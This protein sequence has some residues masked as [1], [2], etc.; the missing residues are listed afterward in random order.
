MLANYL[1]N[2][3]PQTAAVVLAKVQPAY[4]AKVLQQ[5]D[6]NFAMEIISRMLRLE[7]VPKEVLD[8]IER[9]LRNEFMSNVAKAPRRTAAN[10]SPRSSTRSRPTPSAGS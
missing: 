9:I 1:K 3:Y 8:E 10:R 6:D 4:A 7:N 2:E 5:L